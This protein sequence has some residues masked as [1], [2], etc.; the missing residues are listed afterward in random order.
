MQDVVARHVVWHPRTL[1]ISQIPK[2][3]LEY[4]FVSEDY[5]QLHQL[6]WCKDFMQDVVFGFLHGQE[7]SI[8]GF[9]YNPEHDPPLYLDKTRIMLNSYK[10]ADFGSKVLVNLRDF[11]HQ[12]EDR[13]KM[14]RTVFEQVANAPHQYRRSGVF[15][16]DS[17]KRWMKSP[18]MM[19]LYTLLLRT[20]LLHQIDGYFDQDRSWGNKDFQILKDCQRGIESI[21]QQGDR[22]L[23]FSN[24]KDNYPLRHGGMKTSLYTIHDGW[25]LTSFSKKN[26][27]RT[28]PHWHRFD[29]DENLVRK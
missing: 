7:V 11:L 5:I 28:F 15:L 29:E 1:K 17:S 21:F 23:F 19:S 16:L 4:A 20:G 22:R 26:T 18:P 13:L 24:I 2:K 10:D 14:A 25:G 27:K 8:Y 12:I 3:G 6:V 9:R